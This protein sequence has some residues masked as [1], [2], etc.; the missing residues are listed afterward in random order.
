MIE[1]VNKADLI[2]IDEGEVIDRIIDSFKEV[3][4]GD[5]TETILDVNDILDLLHNDPESF[6]KN[7]EKQRDDLADTYD[8]CPLCGL[9]KIF[10]VNRGAE[11]YQSQ[12]VGVMI[13][14]NDCES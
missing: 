11:E 2:D 12:P 8:L 10:A 7:L 3:N 1:M 14:P 6:I 13:C 5:L 4:N 9:E